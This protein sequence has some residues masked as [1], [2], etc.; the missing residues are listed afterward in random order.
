MHHNAF[1]II[2]KGPNKKKKSLSPAARN[3]VKREVSLISMASPAR[4]E[5]PTSV[6]QTRASKHISPGA[7]I[8]WLHFVSIIGYSACAEI[9]IIDP[10]SWIWKKSY[11]PTSSPCLIFIGQIPAVGKIHKR[12]SKTSYLL[13]WTLLDTFRFPKVCS[14]TNN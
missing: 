11:K 9:T 12:N 6:S 1:Q 4:I 2:F 5:L 8:A 7:R 3:C 13:L 14:I 10:I